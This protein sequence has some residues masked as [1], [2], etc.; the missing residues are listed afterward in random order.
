M[1]LLLGLRKPILQTALHARKA[2]WQLQP[3]LFE[4]S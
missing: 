4:R 1:L 3:G 2:R